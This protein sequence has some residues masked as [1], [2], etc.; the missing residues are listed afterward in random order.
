MLAANLN[1][2]DTLRARYEM[3]S[4]STSKGNN[5]KGQPAGTNK[6]KNSNPCL[7]K[8]NI[9][10][11]STIVKLSAKVNAKWLV[12][13]KLYGV[14]PI[15]LLTNINMNKAYIRGKYAWPLFAFI[16]PTTIPCTVA[17]IVSNKTDHPFDRS[18]VLL[19]A[20]KLS[21]NIK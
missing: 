7:L 19:V 15:K 1:P 13:A 8:P 9:V 18:L 4:I 2:K 17:Y 11:P 12:E 21:I 5:P 16:W 6:E 10:A 3:N 20:N 14:I